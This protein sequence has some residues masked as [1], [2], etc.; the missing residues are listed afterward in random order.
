MSCNPC[1]PCGKSTV[2]LNCANL[3]LSITFG[4]IFGFGAYVFTVVNSGPRSASNIEINFIESPLIG[5]DP[6]RQ[7]IARISFIPSGGSAEVRAPVSFL[8][9]TV[10]ATI[11]SSLPQ[12]NGD[13][14]RTVT[15]TIT[16]QP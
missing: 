8:P 11:S 15:Q 9:A 13:L 3:S 6:P 12:C 2:N 14:N 16:G 1:N 4:T 5:P 7:R 10:N